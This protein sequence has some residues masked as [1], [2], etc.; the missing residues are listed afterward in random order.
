MANSVEVVKVE[1]QTMA[2]P[3]LQSSPGMNPMLSGMDAPPEQ[4]SPLKLVVRLLRGRFIWA[5]VLGVIFAG[6]G[7]FVA[8]QLYVP[9]YQSTAML[10]VRAVIPHL[11]YQLEEQRVAGFESFVRTQI[12][13]MT[14]PRILNLAMEDEAWRARGWPAGPTSLEKFGSALQVTNAR[15]SEIV[16]VSFEDENPQTARVAVEAVLRAYMRIFGESDA[17][18]SATRME[19]LRNLRTNLNNELSR[20][21]ENIRTLAG[22]LGEE[23]LEARHKSLLEQESAV[24]AALTLAEQHL[25]ELKPVTN[26]A[27][28]PGD[29]DA[30]DPVI[31]PERVAQFDPVMRS[32]LAERA[33]YERQLRSLSV[34]YGANHFRVR[35]IQGQL[36]ALEAEIH[37]RLTQVFEAPDAQ[38]ATADALDPSLDVNRLRERVEFLRNRLT[39]LRAQLGDI[40]DRRNQ[41][42]RWHDEASNVRQ[43]LDETNRRIEQLNIESSSTI[44]GRIEVVSEAD[45]PVTPVNAKRKLQMVVG[46]TLGGGA[47]GVALV[48]LV[49]FFDPRIRYSDDA[50]QGLG[51]ISMLGML[52]ELN[53]PA[54]DDKYESMT[55]GVQH[56]RTLL[57]IQKGSEGGQTLL[58]TGPSSGSGK[59]T[60]TQALGESFA[61]SG[62]RTLLIDGDLIGARLTRLLVGKQRDDSARKGLVDAVHGEPL[63][64]CI[65]ATDLNN[66]FVMPVGLVADP[67]R[68]G[69]SPDAVRRVLRAVRNQ[70]DTIL[71][72]SGPT[73]G[74]VETSMLAAEADRVVLIVSRGNHRSQYEHSVGHLVSIGARLAGVVFNR[75]H[76]QDMAR[77]A[78]SSTLSVSA[79]SIPADKAARNGHQSILRRPITATD[80]RIS[81]DIADSV[82]V[83]THAESE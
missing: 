17:Q 57:Q 73:P 41:L 25:A 47:L 9:K 76:P 3:G 66:L 61:T 72:D 55:W 26:T 22:E 78:F 8:L 56:I 36:N 54:D 23:G 34:Q 40:V 46:G 63:R 48:M 51:P 60:L 65:M 30:T 16:T 45:T 62:A 10:R 19:V 53:G 12:A 64:D 79:R 75:A 5:A 33:E 58:I 14:S 67:H 29:N 21:R 81:I 7:A 68:S 50:M 6:I 42:A 71:I 49:G 69:F 82:E 35:H 1:P 2:L 43:R 18:A 59:T 37:N 4:G 83:G 39:M 27:N 80:E 28:T 38:L 44:T 11:L 74:P 24:A 15:G 20:L 77:S 32:L 13:Q 52:P 70:F 31:T